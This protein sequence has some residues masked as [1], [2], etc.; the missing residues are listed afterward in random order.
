MNDAADR[1]ADMESRFLRPHESGC[2]E[3][4]E[5]FLLP[6]GSIVR[7]V[8]GAMQSWCHSEQISGVVLIMA[9]R[10]AGSWLNK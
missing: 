7:Q 4:T 3:C 2:A 10:V 1:T 5:Y 8:S 6:E 9:R